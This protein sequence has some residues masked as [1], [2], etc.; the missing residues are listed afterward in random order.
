MTDRGYKSEIIRSEIQKINLIDRNN[1]PKKRPKHQED[2]ITLVL[3]FHPAINIVFDVLN[4]AH[5]HV[6]KSPVLKAV[7][8]KPPRI[9][10]RNPKTLSDKLV[11]SKLK[12]TDDAER[13]NFPCGRGSYEI[14]NILKSGKE[15]KSTIT[16]EIYKMN[17]H[18]E[19]MC[20]LLHYM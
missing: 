12:V 9:A 15:F 10:F 4:R 2:N 20:C 19:L 3:T 17:F 8:P 6:Q 7:L 11:R 14:C 5:R 13:G 16:R 18:F 1:L